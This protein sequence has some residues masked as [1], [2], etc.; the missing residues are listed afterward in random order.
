[1][2]LVTRLLIRVTEPLDRPIN[3]KDLGST[4]TAPVTL[5]HKAKESYVPIISPTP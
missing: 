5:Q 1:M 2:W 3:R 4:V